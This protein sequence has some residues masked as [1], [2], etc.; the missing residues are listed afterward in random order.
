M[1]DRLNYETDYVV[2]GSLPRR[3]EPLAAGETDNRKI[4]EFKQGPKRNTTTIRS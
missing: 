1:A 2:L 3:P 4:A